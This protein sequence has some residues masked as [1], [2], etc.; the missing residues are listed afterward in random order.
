MT[1]FDFADTT[2]PCPKRD[3]TIAAPQALTLFNNEFAH[4]RS[5][6]LARRVA[7]IAGQ[8]RSKGIQLAWRFALGRSPRETE[9]Q[10]AEAHLLSQQR[11]LSAR[12][13]GD[14][15]DGNLEFASMASLCH[16]LLNTNEFAFV[17]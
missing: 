11:R 13:I 16:V 12:P 17:D 6:A 15:P 5:I 3:I 10:A 1:T 9:T 7:A 2:M 14:L 4:E 8:D